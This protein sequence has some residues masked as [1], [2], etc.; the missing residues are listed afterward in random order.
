VTIEPDLPNVE[1]DPNQL[2]TALLN[3][4]L[5]AR[6]AMEDQGEI[7][8]EAQRAII[9]KQRRPNLKPGD[10]VCLSVTDTGHGMDEETLAKAS[11]PFFTT[12]GVGKGT[13]LGLPMVQGF[14]E[15]SGGALI[16][17][18]A[19]GQGTRVEVLL[20]VSSTVI[21]QMGSEPAVQQSNPSGGL[22]LPMKVLVVDDDPLILL[23]AVDMLGELGLTVEEA[24][25]G[26]E[27]L[28]RLEGGSFDLIITDHAMPGMTGAELISKVKLRLP[29]T[30]IVLATGYADLPASA[31]SDFV[32]L[33]KPYTLDDLAA[34]IVLA[35]RN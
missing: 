1:A 12:K 13:G 29:D 2:E 17:K 3:L 22:P 11:D 31:G 21:A 28:D 24:S 26:K 32:R 18:S 14:A 9:T 15:Q 23:N 4:V 35:L 27:A 33:P 16:L 19:R 20:P 7:E 5:N 30:P 34:A 6:D 8:I 10:Y 25:S